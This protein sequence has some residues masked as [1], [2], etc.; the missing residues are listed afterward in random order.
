MKRGRIADGL[1][2]GNA[3]TRSLSSRVSGMDELAILWLGDMLS[4]RLIAIVPAS[5]TMALRSAPT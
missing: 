4:Q 1:T 5:R 3:A 2:K